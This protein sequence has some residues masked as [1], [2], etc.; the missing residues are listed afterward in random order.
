MLAD[1]AEPKSRNGPPGAI[2]FC[3]ISAAMLSA[4]GDSVTLFLSALFAGAVYWVHGDIRS[5]HRNPR[6]G[7]SC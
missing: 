3:P 4:N 2:P 7:R 5:R 1:V 6:G